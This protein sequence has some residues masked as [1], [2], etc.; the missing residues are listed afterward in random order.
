MTKIR[1]Y[2][3]AKKQNVSSKEIIQRLKDLKV[4]VKNHMATIAEDVVEKLNQSF[5]PKSV[6]VKQP[7][8]EKTTPVVR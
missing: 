5:Q 4:D 6:A 8:V 1:I 7:Q 3:Y 2:E